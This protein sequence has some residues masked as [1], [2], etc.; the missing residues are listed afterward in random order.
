MAKLIPSGVVQLPDFAELQYKLNRQKAADELAV[1]KDLAQY[2]QREGIIAPGAMPL[3][4]SEFDNW[5]KAAE[6]YAADPSA[7][8]FT[9]LNKSYDQYA[10]AH[11]TAK[12][13]FDVVKERDAKF[14]SDPTKWG[15]SVDQYASDSDSLVRN[16]YNS[17]DELMTAAS[18]ISELT[19][20]KTVDFT[21]AEE[22]VST[23]VPAWDK[24]YKNL[25]TD[26]NGYVTEDQRDEWFD[27]AWNGQ[28][29]LNEDTRK[30]IILGEVQRQAR[31]GVDKDGLPV[32]LT[33]EQINSVLSNPDLSA[34]YLNDAYSRGR[35]LFNPSASLRYVDPYKVGQDELN[36]RIEILKM[37]SS[38]GEDFPRMTIRQGAPNNPIPVKYKSGTGRQGEFTAQAVVEIPTGSSPTYIDPQTGGEF[39]IRKIMYDL[40]GSPY[41]LRQSDKDGVLGAENIFDVQPVNQEVLGAFSKNDR[42]F[43]NQVMG[44]A[45]FVP[46]EQNVVSSRGASSAEELRQKYNY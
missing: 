28:I 19:P 39:K 36:R 37:R 13:L 1:A 14:Y 9:D 16:R 31:F 22:W 44:G 30:N 4:Q 12:Y 7:S 15:V 29:N 27:Q 45:N 33:Q 25:D 43:L 8:N 26:R 18:S 40:E 2:K 3:V 11:G 6:K 32:Q 5:Q 21:T 41:F 20:R 42:K 23:L 35:A 38:G 46:N 17:F 10:R 24:S 34:K